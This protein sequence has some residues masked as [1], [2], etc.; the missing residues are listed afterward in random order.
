MENQQTH[1]KKFI[2]EWQKSEKT[3]KEYC[4]SKEV[5]VSTL[6]YWMKKIKES[7]HIKPV[8]QDLVRISVPASATGPREI[9]LEVNSRY[10]LIIPNVFDSETLQQI[11]TVIK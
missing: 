2:T 5:K 1:W 11:L 9:I 6:H 3:Q 8:V 10:R 4:R 7:E